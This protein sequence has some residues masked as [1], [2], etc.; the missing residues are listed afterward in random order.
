[1]V[2]HVTDRLVLMGILYVVEPALISNRLVNVGPRKAG[3]AR[4]TWNA[5]EWDSR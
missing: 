1:M 4:H 2:H 3:D 5:H